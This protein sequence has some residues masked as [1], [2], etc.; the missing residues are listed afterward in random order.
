MIEN[1][2]THEVTILVSQFRHILL[3]KTKGPETFKRAWKYFLAIKEKNYRPE[4]TDPIEL[5]NI[6]YAV[7]TLEK[8]GLTTHDGKTSAACMSL[9]ADLGFLGVK[10]SIMDFQDEDKKKVESFIRNMADVLINKT[11]PA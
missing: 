4:P 11:T 9:R 1:R 8:G 5:N 2:F 6:K 10:G 7:E 3:S